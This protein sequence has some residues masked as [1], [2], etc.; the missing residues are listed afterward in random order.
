APLRHAVAFVEDLDFLRSVLAAGVVAV[1]V[2]QLAEDDGRAVA[3]DAGE[4]DRVALEARQLPR[5]VDF[6]VVLPE[7][8]GAALGADVKERLAVGPPHRPAAAAV[9]AEDLGEG[10]LVELVEPDLAGLRALVALAPPGLAFAREE[11]P[12]TVGR[13]GT[14]GAVVVKEYLLGDPFIA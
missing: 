12:F 3:G 9:L 1:E 13:Q 10:L 7:V 4:D 6:Q 14:A 5:R 2:E 8:A 11:Q